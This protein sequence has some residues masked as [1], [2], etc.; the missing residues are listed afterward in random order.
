MARAWSLVACTLLALGSG[1]SVTK[2]AQEGVCDVTGSD[3]CAQS[4]ADDRLQRLQQWALSAGM[5][6]AGKCVHL[7]GRFGVGVVAAEDIRTGD[8]VM[9]VPA[10]LVLSGD[11][12]DTKV[13]RLLP[14]E[15]PIPTVRFFQAVVHTLRALSDPFWGPWVQTLPPEE[16]SSPTA[17]E[18]HHLEALS[19]VS[20]HLGEMAADQKLEYLSA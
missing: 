2:W 16:V 18:D 20:P 8:V 9:R 13:P 15:M 12:Q 14:V 5:T 10:G 6:G 19:Y 11:P 7:G 17:W 4:N 3:G 1:E